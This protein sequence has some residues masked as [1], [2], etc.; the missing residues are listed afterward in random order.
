VSGKARSTKHEIRNEEKEEEITSDIPRDV[1]LG[2]LDMIEDLGQ[3]AGL[4]R[5]AAED[6]DNGNA[7]GG[8]VCGSDAAKMMGDLEAKISTAA[9]LLFMWSDAR[10]RG[11]T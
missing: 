6:T 10:E 8:Q 5:E 3:I 11:G 4:L 7:A 1:R 9:A 2:I